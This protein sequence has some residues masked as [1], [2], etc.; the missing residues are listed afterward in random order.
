[1]NLED[2]ESVPRGR[3]GGEAFLSQRGSR[4]WCLHILAAISQNSLLVYTFQIFIDLPP[5]ISSI[6]L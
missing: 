3:G 5:A 2:S 6:S 4:P 1:M